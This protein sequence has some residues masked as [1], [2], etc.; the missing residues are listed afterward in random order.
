M[1]VRCSFGCWV[2]AALFEP[3]PVW[4]FLAR[5]TG[6]P[7]ESPCKLDRAERGSAHCLQIESQA[8]GREDAWRVC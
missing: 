1:R 2:K 8:P 6:N 7:H 4:I 5:E 3:R